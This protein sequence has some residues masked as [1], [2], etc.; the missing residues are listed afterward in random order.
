MTGA[1]FGSTYLTASQLESTASYQAGDLQGIDLDHDSLSGRRGSTLNFTGQNL[2]GANLSYATL[3]NANLTGAKLTDANLAYAILT[4]PNL[5]SATLVGANLTGVE[6]TSGNLTGADLRAATGFSAN[7]ASA[8][9]TNTILPDGAI[10][11]LTLDINNPTLVVRN[12]SGNIPVHVQQYMTL[13]ASASLVF[14]FDGNPWGSTISFDSGIPVTLGGNLAL[15]AAAGASPSG[16]LSQSLQLFNWTGVSP[17]GQFAQVVSGLPTRYLWD[18]SALYTLGQ[19]GLTLSPTPINGQWATNGSGT[20]SG[21]A[22]WSG[23]NVPGAPQDT[24]IFGPALTSGTAIVTLDTFVSLTSLAFSTTGGASYVINPSYAGTLILSN[25][26]GQATISNTGGSNTIAV[27]IMLESSLSVSTATGS[28]LTIAAAIS[29]SGG[30]RSVSLNG[31]GQ[32]ILGGWNTYTGGT[33][34]SGGTLQLGNANALGTGGLAV[35]AGTVDLAGYSPTVSSLSGVAGTITN[36]GSADSVLT[37]N[38]STATTFSGALTDGATNKLSPF[39][40]RLRALILS[41]TNTYTGG[42][43]VEAGTL[44]LTSNTAIA[45][46]TSLTVG[47]DATLIFDPS[48]AGAPVTNSAAAAAVPEPGSLA[49]LIAGAALL[50]MYRKRR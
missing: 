49:L 19:V 18:T 3:T 16:L 24:A 36:S 43:D 21:A 37:V 42:T 46:G 29:E 7:S 48:A 20:W 25:T 4:N 6:I 11:G 30:G 44:V 38:Q 12:Y 23:G 40:D 17:S 33:T 35:E 50:A 34:V 15:N 9:T 5:S 10:Q 14:E 27:P 45:D 39:A 32:L 47:A 28:S 22:N 26:A 1:N 31:G 41:G 13:T 8:V 2:A